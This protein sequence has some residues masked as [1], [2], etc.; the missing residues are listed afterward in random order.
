MSE[1][2]SNKNIPEVE[3]TFREE[4]KTEEERK[5]EIEELIKKRNELLASMGISIS[6]DS[7]TK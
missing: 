6:N 4:E 7:E 1:Q 3:F 2:E 5:R